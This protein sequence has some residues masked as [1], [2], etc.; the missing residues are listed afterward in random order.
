MNLRRIKRSGRAQ[1]GVTLIELMI[2]LLIGLALLAGIGYVYLQG[3]QGFRVQDNRSRL[4]EDA[5]TVFS[6]I[7]RDILSGGFFGCM[8]TFDPAGEVDSTL[9]IGAAQPIM[10]TNISPFETDRNQ[11]SGTRTLDPGMMIRSF[12]TGE[13]WLPTSVSSRILP[14]TEALMVI[15]GSDETV[16]VAEILPDATTE[17]VNKFKLRAPL[18]GATSGRTHLMVIS[19]CATGE[20]IKGTVAADGVTVS[21][22]RVSNTNNSA[23]VKD[24]LNDDGSLKGAYDDK[25]LVTRFD[26]VVYFVANGVGPD[27][28]QTPNLF[29]MGIRQSNTLNQN[30]LWNN[31]TSQSVVHGV[32]QFTVSYFLADTPTSVGSGPLTAAQV[33]ATNAWA[34]LTAVQLNLTLVSD[35][36]SV[37]TESTTQTV[38]GSST[39]DNKLRYTSSFT[40][41]MRNRR[42]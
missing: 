41:N 35:E 22:D 26:P 7:S 9:Q 6:T 25:S 3:K 18:A 24:V 29:R 11:T 15:R 39:T 2:A 23:T 42:V 10:T 27:G 28:R 19:N 4:Q 5:R 1:Q 32:E 21:T 8:K 12:Q 40:V 16:H 20:L 17:S 31:T 30:G 37:R 36:D 38:G 13:T 14:G 34:N 33:S